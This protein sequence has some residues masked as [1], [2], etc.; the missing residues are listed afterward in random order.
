M[1]TD[2]QTMNL[3][4]KFHISISTQQGNLLIVWMSEN[5]HSELCFEQDESICYYMSDGKQIF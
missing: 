5:F 2:F 1:D 3:I 4:P